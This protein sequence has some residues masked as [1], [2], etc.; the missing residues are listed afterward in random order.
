MSDDSTFDAAKNYKRICYKEDRDLL[1][2]ELNEMQDVGSYDRAMI[3]DRI[4]APGTILSGLDASANGSN[5]TIEDGVVYIDGCAVGVPG[6]TLSF[7]DPGEHTIYVD[8]FRRDVTA[9]EDPTLVNPLTGEAT[10]EREK[11]IATLQSRDTSGDPL[12]QGAKSRSVAPVYIFSRTTGEIRPAAGVAGDGGSLFPELAAALERHKVSDD[13]DGRYYT[14]ALSDGRFTPIGHV[15]AGGTAQHPAATGS[16]AGF[17]SASDKTQLGNHETRVTSI[18]NTLPNKANVSDVTAVC[19]ALNTHKTSSDHDSRYYTKS[20]TDTS[21]ATKADNDDLAAVSDALD[22]H[23]TSADHDSRYYTKTGSDGRYAPVGHVGS[24]GVSQHPVATGSTAGFM[25][26]GD[27]TLL[28]SLNAEVTAARTSETR[29]AFASLDARLENA[30]AAVTALA[31]YVVAAADSVHKSGA[32]YVCDGTADQVEIN[33]ALNALPA[34]GGKVLLLAGTYTLAGSILMPL[35]A[36]LAGEGQATILKLRNAHNASISLIKNKDY[37][38]KTCI[39]DLC[40]DGNKEGQTSGTVIGVE[41]AGES[42]ANLTGYHRMHNVSIT[43]TNLGIFL[44][45]THSCSIFQNS[46]SGSGGILI[47]RIST[48]VSVIGN[49]INYVAVGSGD[50]VVVQSEDDTL[51]K[52]NGTLIAGN[53]MQNCQRGVHIGEG[54]QMCVVESNAI[55]SCH[56]GI[57][58]ASASDDSLRIATGHLVSGNSVIAAQTTGIEMTGI[59]VY[60]ASVVG[61]QLVGSWQAGGGSGRGAIELDDTESVMIQSNTIRKSAGGADHGVLIKSGTDKTWVTNNDLR[62]A[63]VVSGLSDAGTE[64][65]ITPG[66]QV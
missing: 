44:K 13:H 61:N 2:T 34:G 65:Q 54:T 47:T 63:G 45:F 10:A 58:I 25:S 52:I 37:A 35:S 8:V 27:K 6:A 64:T 15:G 24:G 7:P 9:V 4:L 18:E 42:L 23:K 31:T 62:E 36:V 22:T 32:H 66:N 50:G 60:S 57:S 48:N 51:V 21:L 49:T 16:T 30:E 11:W 29:G 17:M 46:L 56:V 1:N 3:L 53:Q 59:G 39:R 12:P 33:Q 55:S 28:D 5:I 26:S 20:Q 14:K 40:I 41:W 19:N 43:N 38:H